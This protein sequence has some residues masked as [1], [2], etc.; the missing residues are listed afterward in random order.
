MRQSW[1]AAAS[2]TSAARRNAS[3][4]WRTTGCTKS[5]SGGSGCDRC[6]RAS[7][8]WLSRL[9]ARMPPYPPFPVAAGPVSPQLAAHLR[10][11]AQRAQPAQ[12]LGDGSHRR[13]VAPAPGGAHRERTHPVARL[14]GDDHAPPGTR[15]RGRHPPARGAQ[16][17]FR[18]GA[19]APVRAHEPRGESQD[20]DG[21]PAHRRVRARAWLAPPS[22]AVDGTQ[23]VPARCPQTSALR[24]A[25]TFSEQLRAPVTARSLRT[26]SRPGP[27]PTRG[28]GWEL[29]AGDAGGMVDW[30][31]RGPGSLPPQ[32]ARQSGWRTRHRQ[33]ASPVRRRHRVDEGTRCMAELD[34]RGREQLR[35]RGSTLRT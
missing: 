19:C 34:V 18:R 30:G 1:P 22:A 21:A 24:V 27:P 25:E 8:A 28:S 3:P 32:S 29:T 23:R 5:S 4:S 7:S 9:T 13:A 17:G 15:G 31:A 11:Q 35:A 20:R 33:A 6:G 12:R 10:Q 26:A 16:R 2:L 14:C